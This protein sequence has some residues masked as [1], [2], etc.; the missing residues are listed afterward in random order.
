MSVEMKAIV[1]CIAL[2]I[3]LGATSDSQKQAP[4]LLL[5]AA[6]CL[7]AKKF[8]R[9]P[10]TAKLT[11]GYLFDQ[12]SYPGDKV[13]YVVKYGVPAGSNGLVFAVFLTERDG[14]QEFNI[15]NNASFILSTTEPIGVSFLSPPL[16]GT[17]TQEHL[18]S[19]V[20]QIEK[21][22]RFMISGAS[23]S[24]VEKSVSCDAYT[25]PQQRTREK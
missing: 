12:R 24:S 14:R 11:F 22:P 4:P 23:L 2:L 7:V 19:A 5:H 20:K 8:L 10:K 16:G 1:L 25:D 15:Q 3:C 6:Q 13:V 21:Q 17:W 9:S 18:A